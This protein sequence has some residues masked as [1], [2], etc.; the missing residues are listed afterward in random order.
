[1]GVWPWGGGRS[2]CCL[3]PVASVL[4][5][6]LPA[7]SPPSRSRARDVLRGSQGPGAAIQR[8]PHCPS[9]AKGPCPLPHVTKVVVGVTGVGPGL[10][11]PCPLARPPLGFQTGSGCSR[12]DPPQ[13]TATGMGGA[14]QRAG[15][16]M[17]QVP[18]TPPRRVPHYREQPP[19]HRACS[20]R[21]WPPAARCSPE[22]RH[23]R[24]GPSSG[25]ISQ[26]PGPVLRGVRDLQMCNPRSREGEPPPRHHTAS[27]R[28]SCPTALPHRGLLTVREDADSL[29]SAPSVPAPS[30]PREAGLPSCSWAP[31]SLPPQLTLEWL[32]EPMTRTVSTPGEARPSVPG[33]TGQQLSPR[34]GP[35]QLPQES[36]R[37]YL[38][39]A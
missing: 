16:G 4:P 35:P 17:L 5:P 15:G 8:P 29:S 6:P 12:A 37:L 33:S 13:K 2:L 36:G 21:E 31:C 38:E 1:M 19:E 27:T 34:F 10:S 11:P 24:G 30:R 28:S 22:P 26:P 9:R 18:S 14:A 7:P 32:A 23:A 3:F 39:D 25:G 20:Q